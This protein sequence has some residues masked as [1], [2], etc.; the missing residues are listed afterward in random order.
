MENKNNIIAVL[1]ILTLTLFNCN[2]E[3]LERY[4]LDE[5]S[6][7]T[8][9]KT[10]NDLA[11]YNNSIYDLTKDDRNSTVL[12]GHATKFPSVSTSYQYVDCF[13]DNIA[14]ANARGRLNRYKD[15]RAGI[16]IPEGVQTYGYKGWDLLR[17]I[18]VGL[19]N[20][21]TSPVEQEVKD[22]YIAEARMFRAWFYYDKVSKFGDVQWVDHEVKTNE[23]DILYGTRDSR[24]FVMEKVLEDINFAVDN[25]PT[26]W[27]DGAAP[28]RLDHWDALALKSRLC[29]FEGTWRKYHGGTDANMWL[30]EAASASKNL[31]E[32]GG[33]S[34]YTSNNPLM[35]YNASH[36]QLNDL[37]G[38]PEIIHWVKY[39]AGVR[40]N[41]VVQYYLYYSGG[42]TKDAIDDYLCDDGLPLA[43]SNR[44]LENT[45][46]EDVFVNRDPRL[47]Q[48]VLHPQDRDVYEYDQGNQVSFPRLIGMSGFE[49]GSTTGYHI[50]KFYNAID[51]ALG[52][53]NHETPAIVFRLGEIYLNYAE[54]MAELGTITQ[55]DLDLTINKLRDRVNM[56]HLTLNPPM[57]PKYAADGVSSLIVEIRRERRIELFSEGFRYDDLR[58]WKQGKKLEKKSYG[59]LWDNAAIARFPGA[60]V[61]TEMI[62]GK[63]YIDVYKGTPWANPVFDE[64]KHYLW[65]IPLSAL[66]QNPELG[67]NPGWEQ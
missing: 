23:D 47:R 46:I 5:L 59:M 61:Q 48:T 8:F 67:Q 13:T 16:H 20:M 19:D 60:N 10:E 58:R 1:L 17:A 12:F 30:Q 43:L 41:N 15:V 40:T 66:G 2:D 21:A 64:S 32:N 9:W 35:D 36:R 63:P 49:E 50:I 18:N 31:I 34:L 28:G 53:N 62:N 39:E 29:L 44:D 38:N 65:P 27:G 51:H 33:Y 57:D 54:A 6:N 45:Q 24:E 37:S 3:F 56:P 22:K 42:M 11:V 52:Y 55:A 14:P 25:L 26:S 7:E 4:P